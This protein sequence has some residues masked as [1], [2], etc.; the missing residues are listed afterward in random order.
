VPSSDYGT[1]CRNAQRKS[2]KDIV[3]AEIVEG[4]QAALAKLK[5]A[6]CPHLLTASLTRFEDR[7]SLGGKAWSV[8]EL[9]PSIFGFAINLKELAARVQGK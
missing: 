7:E 9:K 3:A 8:L 5:L 2:A 6:R 4:L 1:A